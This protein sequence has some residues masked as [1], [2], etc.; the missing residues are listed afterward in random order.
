L[1]FT[2]NIPVEKDIKT[3]LETLGKMIGV[4]CRGR[5]DGRAELCRECRDLLTYAAGRLEKCPH[6]P[7]PSCRGCPTH[8]YAPENR[9]R[10]KEIM[11]YAGPRML[12]RHPL[13]SLKHYLKK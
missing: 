8:C 6:H 2:Y 10:I 9:A 3:E 5:H 13:L 12:L 7:K 4:Y 11:R 1:L